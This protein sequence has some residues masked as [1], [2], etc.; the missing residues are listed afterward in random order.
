MQKIINTFAILGVTATL[1]ACGSS[2]DMEE[3]VVVPVQPEPV[4]TKY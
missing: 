2:N 4:S 1:A 3:V